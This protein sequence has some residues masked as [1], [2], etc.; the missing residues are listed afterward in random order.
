[1]RPR[2]FQKVEFAAH[3]ITERQDE[4]KR[5]RG[6]GLGREGPPPSRILNQTGKIIGCKHQNIVHSSSSIVHLLFCNGAALSMAN[7]Q[8]MMNNEQ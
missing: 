6:V 5:S 7:E 4:R 3:I 1:M 8:S 2:C